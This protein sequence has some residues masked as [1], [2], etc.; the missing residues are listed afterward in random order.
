[1]VL[2]LV[3]DKC[4]LGY[5]TFITEIAG[6]VLD[7]G[8]LGHVDL[9]VVGL[10][11]HLATH[12]AGHHHPPPTPSLPCPIADGQVLL[13]TQAAHCFSTQIAER[14]LGHSFL[15]LLSVLHL[16]VL[17]QLHPVLQHLL[18]LAAL[19]GG[20]VPGDVS[21]DLELGGEGL[22]AEAAGDDLLKL[23]VNR[24]DVRSET[25]LGLVLGPTQLTGVLP[26]LGV[27]LQVTLHPILGDH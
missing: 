19:D 10:L 17:R 15:D 4:P 16:H 2:L 3:L 13:K 8:V 25:H 18:A 20:V 1:M 24:P 23:G 26:L 9:Q 5:K 12:L 14:G 6:K 27:G 7:S 11:E 22:A 21:L